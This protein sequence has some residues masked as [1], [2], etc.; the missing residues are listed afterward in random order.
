MR[1]I[2]GK[3]RLRIT[4][5]SLPFGFRFPTL[6]ISPGRFRR[7]ETPGPP[8]GFGNARVAYNLKNG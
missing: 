6:I 2:G 4:E 8:G 5:R 3:I 7:L 1:V